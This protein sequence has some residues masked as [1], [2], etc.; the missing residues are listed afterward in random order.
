MG[1]HP[2]G[3][4]RDTSYITDAWDLCGSGSVNGSSGL[5][6]KKQERTFQ[7]CRGNIPYIRSSWRRYAGDHGKQPG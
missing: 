2:G 7:G 6:H 5:W 1:L 3:F 4:S